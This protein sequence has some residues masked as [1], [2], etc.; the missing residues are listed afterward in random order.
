MKKASILVCM[1]LCAAFAA[2]AQSGYN[3]PDLGYRFIGGDFPNDPFNTQIYE[4][5][6]GM[7][8]Y[9]SV[10]KAKPRVYTAIAVRTGSR[11][12]PPDKTGLAHYLE[13]LL[14]KGTDQIATLDWEKEKVYLDRIEELY[15][16]H[17][18]AKTE[19]A[20][21]E[22]Y[23]EIDSVAGLAAQYAVPGEWD[24]MTRSLGAEGTN[25]F[26]SNDQTVYIN[27][28]PSNEIERWA[29]METERLSYPVFRLFHTELETVYEEKN[30]AID[31]DGRRA[32]KAMNAFL[33]AGHPYGTQTTLGTSEHLKEPS[34]KR[35]REY[36][37]TYYVPNNMAICISG[38]IDPKKTMDLLAP[39]F[40]KLR[41]K[42]VAQPAVPPVKPLTGRVE[43]TVTGPNAP[44]VQIGFQLPGSKEHDLNVV[45]IIS[46]LLSDNEIGLI[47]SK[48]TRNNKI[49]RAWSY[50]DGKK[51]H[52]AFLIQGY[53][54]EGQSLK[55]VEALLLAELENIKQGKFDHSL[56][57]AINR[58]AQ[59]SEIREQQSNRARAFNHVFAYTQEIPW[60]TN[61]ARREARNNLTADDVIAAANKYFGDAYAVIYKEK[62]ENP[63]AEKFEKPPITPVDIN[64]DAHSEIYKRVLDMSPPELEPLFIDFDE[65]IATEEM[66]GAAT[67]HYIKNEENELFT[68]YYL[69][70]IGSLHDQE[71]ALAVDYLDYL[72]TDELTGEELR[73]EFYKLGASF[74]VYSS[75]RRT[76]VYLTGLQSAFEPSIKLFEKFIANAKPDAE[77]YKTMIDKVLK[78]REN[79]K[80]SQWA[81]LNYAMREY[82]EYGKDNPLRAQLSAEQL[83]AM[84]PEKLTERV[85]TMLEYP[86]RI[87][88]YGPADQGEIKS[89]LAKYHKAPQ[90][91]RK[92]PAEREF[93][94]LDLDKNKI[95]IMDYDMVQAQALWVHNSVKY[96]PELAPIVELFNKY[97]GAGG[98]SSLVFQEIRESQGLAYTAYAS[99][100]EPAR[101]DERY[102]LIGY[103][104]TQA[105]KTPEALGSMM[106]LFE[107]M[108]EAEQNLESAQASVRR[109][110]ASDRVIRASKFFTWMDAQDMGVDHDMR[111]DV[112][113]K[114]PE[115]TLEDLKKFH[116]DHLK[117]KHFS[118]MILADKERLD[119]DAL[120]K[121]GEVEFL[122]LEEVFGY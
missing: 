39:H 121:F 29:L 17:N 32:R 74:G 88:Y 30:R 79:M 62:G 36:F 1:M 55:E 119:L 89:A 8:V 60:E 86:H 10:N 105:D 59:I 63:D 103:V 106:K 50:L 52:S 2:T 35:I 92:A 69:L 26:T 102:T 68:L 109:S 73:K 90:K 37:N 34:I 23:K 75:S 101:K 18:A 53:P 27:D 95:Y 118:I 116:N 97:F 65:E 82:A 78:D 61:T 85:H 47:P 98:L 31:N 87:M 66:S 3:P 117:D 80:S 83:R 64:R 51:E 115:L 19:E 44:Y 28:I 58:N 91:P 9:L 42:E 11:N 25:A 6:N 94:R 38:D 70:E 41:A 111:K 120:E 7:R 14:F 96:D 108:P 20:R 81:I 49:Q 84:Q 110:I 54:A 43:E 76:Y 100:S 114:T 71:L 40:N 113:E 99:F 13:H 15:E 5:A 93:K 16:K 33:Y 4:L 107:K 45:G 56:V 57:E 21:L 72:G 22:I 77:K 67:F 12:D 48:L 46:S 112:Y 104:G 24:Q 122:T